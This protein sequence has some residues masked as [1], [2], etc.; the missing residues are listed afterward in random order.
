MSDS[1]RPSGRAP[2]QLRNVRFERGFTRHAE[3]SVLVSFGDTRVLCNASVESRVPAFLRGKGEGWVTAEY[4]M[5]PRATNTR[6]DREAARGKQ[7]GRTLEIQR[8]IGRSLR[9]CVDRRA[10]GER[11]ITLDCDVLQADGGTRTAAI[12]GAYVALVDAIRALQARRELVRDPVHGAIAAVS[13]GVYRGVPVLDLD[14][15]E[16]SDCDTDMNV[17]MNDGG[18]F[19]EIQGTAEGHAFRRAE[20]DAMLGLAE[21]GIAELVALQRAALAG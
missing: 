21:T 9:A 12:T 8:L 11:T 3:G 17:V 13:V 10:L 14:Y 18:G 5:L 4:G 16:D 2:G 19:I 15:A 7:G 20:M 6:N 1:S